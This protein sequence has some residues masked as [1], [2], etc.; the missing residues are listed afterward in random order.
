MADI[1]VAPAASSCSARAPPSSRRPGRDEHGSA[2]QQGRQDPRPTNESPTISDISEPTAGSGVAGRRSPSRGA[3]PRPGSRARR[4]GSRTG[5][6]RHQQ[7]HR[8]ERDGTHR[9]P[10]VAVPSGSLMPISVAWTPSGDGGRADSRPAAGSVGRQGQSTSSRTTASASSR[11][12]RVNRSRSSVT[13]TSDRAA[14][15]SSRA[16]PRSRRADRAASPRP[17]GSPAAPAPAPVV[18]GQDL[19]GLGRRLSGGEPGGVRGRVLDVPPAGATHVAVGAGPDPPPVV[20]APVAQIVPAGGV[21]AGGPV[22]HLV[23]AR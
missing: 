10:G 17:A 1:A 9:P 18:G 14:R 3:D 2:G 21:G 8:P 13:A 5:P 20:P 15:S 19:P 11:P 6:R 23:R 16:R 12:F 22:G 4:G 7:R